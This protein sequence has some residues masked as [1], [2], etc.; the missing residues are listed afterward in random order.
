MCFNTI[1]CDVAQW[2]N[3]SLSIHGFL[4]YVVLK[5]ETNDYLQ[6]QIVTTCISAVSV[7]SCQTAQIWLYLFANKFDFKI[8]PR[9]W[10]H[11]FSYCKRSLSNEKR[12]AT[13]HYFT[14]KSKAMRN[15]TIFT[16]KDIIGKGNYFLIL[17]CIEYTLKWYEHICRE[18][19]WLRSF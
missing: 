12:I 14:R 13:F 18:W 11:N 10:N 16:H 9:F 15:S 7:M 3:Y 17:T 8:F 1:C 2:I 19:N 4:K 5:Y 6:L